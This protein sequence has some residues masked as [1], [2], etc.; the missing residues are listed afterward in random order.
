MLDL[1]KRSIMYLPGVGP[2]KAEILQ[3]EAGISSYEDML[4]YFPYKYIDRS[5]FYKVAEVT[6][7]MPYIQMKG[8][9]LFF[10]TV[11]EGRTRRLIGKF[12]DGTGTID[13]VW[14]K[15][16][17]YVLDKIKTGVDY[18][19]FGKPTEFGHIYNIPHPDIDPLDQADK[20]ANG[21]T[22]FYNTSEKMKKSFLN[23]RAIQNL[24]YTLLSGLN[25]T[26]PETLPPDVLNRIRMMSFPEAIRN[27]HFPESVDKL[28]KAQLR[29]KFDELFF[30]QLNILRTSNLRKLKLR[31]IVFPSVGDYFNTFY[32][33]Y[34]PF[35]LTNAQKRV[36]REIRADM[37]SGRQMNRLLQGDVGSGKTLVALMSMLLALDN[38]YQA[39]MMAPTEILANQ[40]YETIKELLF[41]MDIRVELLTGSIK[42]KRREAI[43][44]GL[45]TGDVQILIGTHAVIEDTVNFSSLGFVVI[46]EQHRFG[47]AQRARLWSKNVQPPHVLVMTATPI[48]R[49]L[50]MTLYGDLDVSVI[51]ELPPGRKP[52]TTIHQ[53][54]NR[55]ESMYRSVRKQI[56][57]G[58]QVYIVY[59]LIKESEKID[60]KN[61][62]EG[63]QHI[64]EEFPK[65]TVCKVH[66]KMKPAEKDEQM[67]LFVSGKAQIM[68]ATTVIEVGVNVPNASVMI[69]ENAERFGLSQLHQLRGRV[70]RGAE[71][72]YCILVTNYKLT[73]DTR[74]RL[75]IMVRTNDGFE[76]AEADLKLRGPGDLEGTQQSGIAFDLKIADIVRD[77]QLLQYV[78]AIAESIV[79]QDPAAQSPENE[80]LWRQLKALRKTNVNWAAIS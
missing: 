59:P 76:I 69:I 47:V 27:V 20:V 62:E 55:R 4:F 74:K 64:L 46:D 58:R 11:G 7:D 39:C 1:D 66:G 10:D 75:E 34:L 15:G 49:T 29:L 70:G 32:K 60:L 2:K 6:G 5:R 31:G 21:L 25:W 41:G 56:E 9:I 50:A 36:V 68:V 67:Q 45:L 19:V 42:G 51:D 14:F 79:E 26:L 44:A 35:E 24:Q 8:R 65:C 71:Q 18:I 17:N 16:I 52:I 12:T 40:H 48:P 22:P 53:F 72:S 78:R 77:G 28:R 38:G 30:I 33:E 80:I 73:E 57:E 37:G 23:S 3:K 61:L 63:Y 43:L 13:L 54:D